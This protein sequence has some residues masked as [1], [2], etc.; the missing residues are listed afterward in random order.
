MRKYKNFAISIIYYWRLLYVKRKQKFFFPEA[1]Y[2]FADVN[3]YFV[4]EKSLFRLG[5][6]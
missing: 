6:F 2:Y 3:Y 5:I 4:G 1:S